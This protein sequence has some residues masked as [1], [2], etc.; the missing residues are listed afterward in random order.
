MGKKVKKHRLFV[1]A[2][3]LVLAAGTSV[4]QDY[5]PIV[6]TSPGFSFQHNSPVLGGSQSFNCAGGGST[7][8]YNPTSVFGFAA[9]LSGCK[10]F[11][12][13]NTYGVGSKVNGGEFT[14]VF[15]P[16]LTVRKG[17]FQPFF[18]VNFGGERVSVSCRNG[19]AGNACGSITTGELPTQLPSGPGNFVTVLNPN[20][21]SFAKN[22]FA[23]TVGGGFDIRVSK[24]FAIRLVQAEYLYTR[25][26]NSCEFAICSNNNSQNSF[27]LKSGIVIGWGGERAEAVPPPPAPKMKACAGG[28]SVP[29]DQECPKRDIS[30]GIQAN[31]TAICPGS[32]SKVSPPAGLPEGA[33]TQWSVNGQQISQAGTLEFGST[34]RDAGA[35]T[36]ALNV[37]AE[38]YN[39]ASAQTTV[40]VRG[41][42]PPSGNVS[43]SPAEIWVGE[44]AT[45]AANFAPGQCGG[46]LGQVVFASAEG[47][48]NGNVFD[49]SG[50][51]FDPANTSE[52]QKTIAIT[53]KVADDQGSGSAQTSVV[54]K[55]KAAIA[56][57]RFP[58][59]VFPKNSARVNN[60]GKRVLL[61]ELKGSLD[62]DPNGHV[63]FV[64]HIASNEPGGV[65]LGL[66][67]ALNAAAVISAGAQICLGFSAANI[68]VA[69]AGVADNGVD[70][71]PYFCESST[72]E[73]RGNLVQEADSEAKN[74]RVEVWFVPAGGATP[75]SVQGSHSAVE[76]NVQALGCPR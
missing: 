14:Y 25:F 13:N 66:N 40:T 35:Y 16:R 38:G 10:A 52:Q 48:V 73:I 61:E 71:Q 44:K 41:Y 37:S 76:L 15:G 51:Q 72:G 70:F 63:V 7:I 8:A 42:T 17:K 46:P 5:F 74:R 33:A 43:A 69:S 67:R 1:F 39:P 60:C 29:V 12:L 11:G 6:E 27:R 36:V 18:E 22:A 32:V 68:L 3:V 58:D 65:D 20:A 30:L 47:S 21:T 31:P 2:G 24:K 4:A 45:L 75:A 57:K 19:N 50:V 59:I 64:G 53:A 49:S 62:S 56:A 28:P 54:V 34:G 26:G 23:M 9:D 55:Q